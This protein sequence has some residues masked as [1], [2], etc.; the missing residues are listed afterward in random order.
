[1]RARSIP[2]YLTLAGVTIGAGLASRR[3]AEIFPGFIARYAGDALWAATVFW[4]L[5]LMR[6]RAATSRIAAGAVAISFIVEFSQLYRAPWIDAIRES[7]VGL[8]ILGT[9]FLWSELVCYTAGVCIAAAC[10][11]LRARNTMRTT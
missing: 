8:L 5:A 11:A 1:M 3:Y 10:D 9:G 2:L 4:L 7:R 6:R